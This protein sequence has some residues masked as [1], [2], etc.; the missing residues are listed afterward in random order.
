MG[1]GGGPAVVLPSV[2]STITFTGLV[3]V[4]NSWVAVAKA[5]PW[6]VLPPAVRASTA[7]F[8]WLTEAV[9]GASTTADEEK[10]TTPMRVPEPKSPLP[11]PSSVACCMMSIKVSDP[12]FMA[13]SGTPDMLP[14]RSST[15]TIS[16]GFSMMSGAAVS[17]SVT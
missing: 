12:S 1:A 4:S 8:S 2:N 14:E 11:L 3:P 13:A 6:L 7:P 17:A 10:L 9:K 16:V 5:S 15:N